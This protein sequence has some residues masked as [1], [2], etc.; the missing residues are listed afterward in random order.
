[1]KTSTIY[2]LPPLG[3]L[4]HFQFRFSSL[5]S[6]F[7]LSV[8]VVPI[9]EGEKKAYSLRLQEHFSQKSLISSHFSKHTIP[10]AHTKVRMHCPKT[11]HVLH[12]TVLG[13]FQK[14]I[15]GSKKKKIHIHIYGYMLSFQTAKEFFLHQAEV[16]KYFC[17]N[18][19][20]KIKRPI[21]CV[22]HLSLLILYE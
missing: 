20:R 7:L 15:T 4:K 21:H 5:P 16:C 1:M 19:T 18:G 2:P 14:S 10:R 12:K 6:K 13:T 11:A 3:S 8:W 9:K 22:S 17:E